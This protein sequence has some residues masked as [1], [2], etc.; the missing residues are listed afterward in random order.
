MTV[1]ETALSVMKPVLRGWARLC[2]QEKVL[3]VLRPLG[4][5]LFGPELFFL[6]LGGA[7]SWLLCPKLSGDQPQALWALCHE[8]G[9]SIIRITHPSGHG[10]QVTNFSSHRVS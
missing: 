4:L 1:C 8:C 5:T 3:C 9:L 7:G 6:P 2:L 10:L